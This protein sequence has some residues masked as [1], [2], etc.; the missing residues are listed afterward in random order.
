MASAREYTLLCLK[1][2]EKIEFSKCNP[3]MNDKTCRYDSCRY[4]VY[5][6]VS[7]AY[8]HALLNNCNREGLTCTSLNEEYKL[9]TIPPEMTIN[10]PNNDLIVYNSKKILLDIGVNEP[11]SLYYLDNT[12]G[13]AIK[14]CSKCEEYS[15]NKYF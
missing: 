6:G 11:S 1:K 9:D 2:G 7:G 5:N 8:C 3:R 14:L 10:N 13:R 12:G 15:Q 4:C